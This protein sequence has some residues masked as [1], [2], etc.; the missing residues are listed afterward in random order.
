MLAD[1][2]C[3]ILNDTL[4]IYHDKQKNKKSD[5]TVEDICFKSTTVAQA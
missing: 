1:Q 2:D 4:Q 5:S 3:R